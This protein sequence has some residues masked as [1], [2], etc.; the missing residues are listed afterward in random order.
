[1]VA[2]AVITVT[3]STPP[4]KHRRNTTSLLTIH[5]TSHNLLAAFRCNRLTITFTNLD[6]PHL[7]SLAMLYL[8]FISA[9]LLATSATAMP[10]P[11]HPKLSLLNSFMQPTRHTTPTTA[12]LTCGLDQYDFSSLMT[13]DWSGLSDDY[14]E[15]YYV[16]LCHTVQNL[17]CT[18]NPGT[19][20]VQVCQVSPDDTQYTYNLMSNDTAATHWSYING[21]DG[22]DGVQFESQTG[23]ASQGCPNQGQRITIGRLVCGNST[24]TVVDVVENPACTYTMTLPNTVVCQKGQTVDTYTAEVER[25]K[26]AIEDV[27]SK[28]VE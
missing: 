10:L 2:T 20:S 12:A 28:Q 6:W 26:R 24:G 23:D 1:M 27:R 14:S 7:P 16:N 11:T 19:A 8:F 17:W 5:C 21:K 13:A 9:L 18:L 3:T 22:G 15:I 4:N 25:V